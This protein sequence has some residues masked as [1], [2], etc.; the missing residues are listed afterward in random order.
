MAMGRLGAGFVMFLVGRGQHGVG[1][2]PLSDP[3]V[4]VGP[5]SARS[6]GWTGETVA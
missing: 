4:V 2:F 1:V 6:G 5:P 3:R